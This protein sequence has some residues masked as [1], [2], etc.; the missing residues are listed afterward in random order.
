MTDETNSH[1]SDLRDK[2]TSRNAHVGIVGLGYV[3][4]PLA[5]TCVKNGY[6]VT[7]YDNNE[8][9]IQTLQ[10]G[11]SPIKTFSGSWVK[12]KIEEGTFRP[13]NDPQELAETDV[14]LICVPTPL[15]DEQTP[16]TSF[17]EGAGKLVRDQLT[18][19]KLV[20]LESTT[21]PGTTRDLLKPIL[22]QS[23]LRAGEN[24][25][26]AYSPEREDP[27]NEMYSV[28]NIPKVVGGHDDLSQ[29][30]ATQFYQSVMVS[31]VP[32]NS[33]E[34]AEATK[35]ME[36]IFRA[37][38][39]A[40]VNEMK[41]V[42]SEMD[43]DVWNVIR[44]A[45]TKPFGYMPF[46]PG[47]GVGGHCIPKDLYY[48]IW[49]AKENGLSM[50]FL[51][52][53]GR[54]NNAMPEVI[55]K[56]IAHTLKENGNDLQNVRGLLLGMAYKPDVDDVRE[57]PGLKIF[58]QLEEFGISMA[59]H[60]P[61]VPSVPASHQHARELQSVSPYPDVLSQYDFVVVATDHSTYDPTTI[62]RHAHLVFDSRN[63]MNGVDGSEKVIPV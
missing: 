9:K 10:S 15:T 18:P 56:K 16:D 4:L 41:Q 61:F 3:G 42:L 45:S 32:M 47:P 29:Q 52:Q 31:I 17:I 36:N 8:E 55:A 1:F 63:L 46:F 35:L 30:L 50:D 49:K 34:E 11:Q 27:G 51:E 58:H 12:Q 33:T 28:E 37:A 26:L 38:N 6:R 54:V 62:L 24:F 13:T 5:K 44:A 40:L 60:D 57:S 43:I 48:M 20:I 23:G 53:A 7:G 19:G 25:Y 14:I 21:Y 39:I 59:Y 2:I 22:E